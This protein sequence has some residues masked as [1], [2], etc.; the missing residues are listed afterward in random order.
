MKGYF[1]VVSDPQIF[2]R[3]HL[4]RQIQLQNEFVRRG[5]EYQIKINNIDIINAAVQ[6]NHTII[7]D[8]S[9][10]D[11]EPP[12]SYLN[13]FSQSIGFDWSGEFM[14]DLNLVVVKHPMRQYKAKIATEYGFHNLIINKNLPEARL[15]QES[16]SQEFLLISL[17]YS[18]KGGS[19]L[20]ALAERQALSSMPVIMV[21]GRDLELVLPNNCQVVVDPPN[22]L[23]LMASAKAVIS[24]G[25]TTYVESLLLGKSV[26]PMPQTS[27]EQ[28]FVESLNDLTIKNSRFSGFRSLDFEKAMKA[29]MDTN[30]ADRL[31]MQ[32]LGII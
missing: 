1:C 21:A 6:Q 14:P 7:L 13:Q 2:G 8:L 26:L 5:F 9:I 31:C 24:N 4:A 3:G 10:N 15:A 25:G 32:I 28:F 27:E 17:G 11:L 18:T 23:E 20:C 22:F 30:G 12:L 29:G 16:T 19:Y